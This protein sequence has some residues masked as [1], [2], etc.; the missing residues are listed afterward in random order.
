MTDTNNNADSAA[1][2]L[3]ESQAKAVAQAVFNLFPTFEPKGFAREAIMEG[4]VNGLGAAIMMGQ[5]I[6]RFQFADVLSGMA[7]VFRA[8]TPPEKGKLHVVR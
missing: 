8:P 6:D 7:D 4:V 3:H 1:A 5:G 2:E